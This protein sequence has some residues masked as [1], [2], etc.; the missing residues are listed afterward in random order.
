MIAAI[1]R[2]VRWRCTIRR[3]AAIFAVVAAI[4][5]GIANRCPTMLERVSD[6]IWMAPWK[7][8]GTM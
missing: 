1:R 3:N 8:H 7:F 6:Q 4:S 5:T 2:G